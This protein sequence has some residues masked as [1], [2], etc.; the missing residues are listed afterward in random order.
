MTKDDWVALI[1]E[2]ITDGFVPRGHVHPGVG[3]LADA[4][5]A[6]HSAS[7]ARIVAIILGTL[8]DGEWNSAIA[9]VREMCLSQINASSRRMDRGA[10]YQEMYFALSAMLRQPDAE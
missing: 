4:I 9:A 5:I 3:K 2:L 10:I 7:A 1:E 8:P 6:E